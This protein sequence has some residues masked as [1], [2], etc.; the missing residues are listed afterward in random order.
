[1]PLKLNSSGG[2]SVT[3]DTPSTASTFTLTV[4]AITGTAVVTG[5]SATVSQGMLAAGVAGN[6]PVFYATKSG[7]QSVSN[8]TQTKITVTVEQFDTASCYDT[9]TSRFTPNVAGYYQINYSVYGGGT[10]NTQAVISAI[11]KNGA[12]YGSINIS[13]TYVYVPAAYSDGSSTGSCLVYMNGSSDYL[14]LYGLILGSGTLNISQARFE[15][16]LVRSA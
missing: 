3:L 13:G 10:T 1:M 12:I 7:S 9:S 14:E 6:G 16:S 4:P 5:S 11:Y 15:G 2:G 8:N